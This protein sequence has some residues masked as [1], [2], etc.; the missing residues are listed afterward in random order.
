MIE[1]E[2]RFPGGTPL[3][4]TLTMQRSISKLADAGKM[5]T[6]ITSRK[7]SVS[8]DSSSDSTK[9]IWHKSAPSAVRRAFRAD[10]GSKGWRAWTEHLAERDDPAE[11]TELLPGK[12]WPLGWAPP[13]G[14][15]SLPASD[16]LDCIEQI[17]RGGKPDEPA[18]GTVLAWLADATDGPVDPVQALE[19]VAWCHALPRLAGLIPAEAWWDLFE[20]LLGTVAEA[21]RIDLNDDP[22]VHQ[23]L[24][25]E[26]PLTLAWLFPEI[27]PA[28]KLARNARKALSA[29][30]VEL[31]DGEG[32]L[33][34]KHLGLLRSLL[35]CWTRCLAVSE[36]PAKSCFDKSATNQY[37]WF[38]RGAV[39][40]VRQD[41]THVFSDGPSGQ[42]CAGLFQAALRFGGDDDDRAIAKLALPAKKQKNKDKSKRAGRRRLPDAAVHSQWASV[43]VLRPG[44]SRSAPRLTALFPEAELRTELECKGDV[45]WSGVWELDVRLDGKPAP[46][47]SNWEEVCWVSDDEVDYLE[48]EID[49]AD[50]LRVQRQMLL[51]RD[52]GFLFLADVLLGNRRRMIEYRSCLPLASGISFA[53]EGDSREGLL[54]AKKRRAL[55]LPLALP[56]WRSDSRVGSLAR[57]DRGLELR[58]SA[59]CQSM[60]APLLFDLDSHRMTRSLTWRR[61]TVAESLETQPADV[62]VGY[63][64]QIGK[65]QWLIYRSLA[66]KANRT[67]LGHNLSSEMLVAQFDPYGEIDPLLEI[68]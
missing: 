31:C 13:D 66:Q 9:S 47:Q 29:G 33:D 38:V 68:E 53:G 44:W 35:A 67:L 64:V 10:D 41:G 49:L 58:Q 15:Q 11:L 54:A 42:W 24:A 48:L 26:L 5:A 63:R 2:A 40:F 65:E 1:G 57:T 37:E 52:D 19:A 34:A 16:T 20:H 8:P 32:M 43:S 51:A 59:E 50:D 55:V 21:G 39:R 3:I 45:L 46:A 27:A 22:L 17:C 14:L 62:A 61:L 18:A 12:C 36:V 56:E 6:S 25:G 7:T 4:R 23:L 28:R 60:Y 30:P